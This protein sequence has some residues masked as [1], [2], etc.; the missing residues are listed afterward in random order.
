MMRQN[1]I[2]KVIKLNGVGLHTGVLV[3]VEIHP[4]D[5][6]GIK[7]FRNDLKGCPEILP[8][9]LHVTDTFNCTK[10]GNSK[11]EVGV[12]E[13]L[14]SAFFGLG[15]DQAKIYVDGPELPILDGSAKP[16]VEAILEAGIVET[17][18]EVETFVIEKPIFYKDESGSEYMA[19]PDD[20]FDITVMIDYSNKLIGKQ[21]AQYRMDTD[22]KSE[23]A[24]AR[25]FALTDEIL[26][27]REHGLING[28]SLEN[29]VIFKGEL[30]EEKIS[31]LAASLGQPDISEVSPGIYSSEPL[32]FA[33]EPARHKVL[34]L[35]GDMS[36]IGKRIQGKVI[37]TRP[38]HRGNLAFTKILRKK[39]VEQ[40]K[41]KG[42]PKYDV[43]TPPIMD[44]VKIQELIPHRYPFLL[45]DK[46]TELSD[47]VVVGIKNISIDMPVFQGHFPGHPVFP[48]VLQIEAMAQTGGILVMSGYDKPEEYDTYFVKIDNAKFKH[49]VVPG[50]TLIIKM[51]LMG[52]MK[53][54]LVSMRGTTYVGDK[55][56]SEGEFI[57]RIMHQDQSRG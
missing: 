48:G 3:N 18:L 44:V 22:Y 42:R 36:L 1:T 4:S 11:A 27:L 30:S 14:L 8:D 55:L 54:G 5:E 17:E 39:F 32:R 43:S 45:V 2:G 50:D 53:R 33:N 40:R 51:E 13:H 7:F 25:T 46:I 15:I 12:I 6:K 47:T 9:T 52:P 24:P 20:G 29:A 56:V 10:I 16:F 19:L 31:A 35:I 34:D 37:A 28:G 26:A 49:V 38:S 41:L 23:I 21:Y 57:A